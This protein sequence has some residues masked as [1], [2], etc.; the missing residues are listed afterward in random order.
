MPPEVI[1][2][3]QLAIMEARKPSKEDGISDN[4]S[5]ITDIRANTAQSGEG[6]A[7]SNAETQTS[8]GGISL[9]NIIRN[10]RVESSNSEVSHASI[11][12]DDPSCS[13]I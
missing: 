11:N 7:R 3:H 13:D 6:E 4:D 2:N 12:Q 8:I 5:E 1:K 10:N 9:E